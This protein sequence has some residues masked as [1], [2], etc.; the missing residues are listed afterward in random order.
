MKDEIIEELWAV[1]DEIA[2]QHGYDLETLV[3]HLNSSSDENEPH[4]N[5][6]A[7]ESAAKPSP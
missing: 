3:A 5:I 6:G 7:A 1:K 4:L 2:E